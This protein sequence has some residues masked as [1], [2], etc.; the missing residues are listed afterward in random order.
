MEEIKVGDYVFV[1]SIRRWGRVAS[2][3]LA[4]SC[5][6]FVLDEGGHYS[7]DDM[8]KHPVIP[9]KPKKTVEGTGWVRSSCIY[10]SP[11]CDDTFTR[12]TYRVEE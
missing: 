10:D 1:W 6:R 3:C 5:K 9:P 2:E 7:S 12:V 4:P 11:G 8:S